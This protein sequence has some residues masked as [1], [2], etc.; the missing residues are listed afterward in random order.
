MPFKQGFYKQGDSL[1]HIMENSDTAYGSESFSVHDWTND[2]YF[3]WD[4]IPTDAQ[5]LHAYYGSD[6]VQRFLK[7]N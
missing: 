1:L 5:F 2:E 4:A 6:E 3:V 7:S